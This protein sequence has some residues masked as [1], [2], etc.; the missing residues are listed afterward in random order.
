ML[1]LSVLGALESAYLTIP[2]GWVHRLVL[3]CVSSSNTAVIFLMHLPLTGVQKHVQG[4]FGREKGKP[5]GVPSA[6]SGVPCGYPH[7]AIPV[8]DPDDRDLTPSSLMF[9]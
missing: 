2:H 3:I 9:K 6:N 4:S 8:S 7:L 5:P 1:S